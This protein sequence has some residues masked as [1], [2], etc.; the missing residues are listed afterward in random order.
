MKKA[1]FAI[2]ISLALA[3]CGDDCSSVNSDT[4]SPNA[5]DDPNTTS[6]T[7]KVDEAQQLIIRTIDHLSSNLCIQENNSW[8]WKSLDFSA[9]TDTLRYE[10]RGDTLLLYEL[11]MNEGL[12]YIGGTGGNLYGT[13]KNTHCSFNKRDS[14]TSCPRVQQFFEAVAEISPN[15]ITAKKIISYELFSSLT[16]STDYMNSS[17]MDDIYIILSGGSD[18]NDEIAREIMLEKEK[19]GIPEKY[20]VNIIENSKREQTFSLH[21]KRYTVT[22]RKIE[23][24][25]ISLNEI[26]NEFS[27]DVSDENT[28]CNVIYI[29]K[30]MTKELCSDS[31]KEYYKTSSITDIDN[32]EY[33]CAHT[34]FIS[35]DRE[36]K[37]CLRGIAVTGP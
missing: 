19:E 3:A 36:F 4:S 28:V 5:N 24:S 23:R 35:N 17:F 21:D 6:Y 13:W 26:N 20:G 12:E 29:S 32:N 8:I 14:T 7:I 27:I 2:T 25:M 1:L 33:R 11:N 15:K 10:F 22:V 9:Q 18:Y 34:Y 16:D 30:W 31:Y 37:E